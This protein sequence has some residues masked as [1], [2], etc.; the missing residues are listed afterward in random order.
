MRIS[1][2]ET[3]FFVNIGA[4][5]IGFAPRLAKQGSNGIIVKG[6]HGPPFFLAAKAKTTIPPFNPVIYY[7]GA[8]EECARRVAVTTRNPFHGN[9]NSSSGNSTANPFAS[10][11]SFASGNMNVR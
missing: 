4:S 8:G 7:R 5:R 9:A 2:N 6:A 1:E 3:T 11:S 10:S